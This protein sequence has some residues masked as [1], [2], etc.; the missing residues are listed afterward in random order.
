VFLDRSVYFNLRDILPKSGIFLP[1]YPVYRIDVNYL[2]ED[3]QD[4]FETCQIYDKLYVKIT[5]LTLMYLLA[6]LCL[7]FD[8]VRI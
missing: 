8:N 1:G 7:L 3:D 2:P 6:L 5:V 4:R